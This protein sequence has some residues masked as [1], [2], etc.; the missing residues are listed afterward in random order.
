MNGS[1]FSFSGAFSP[2]GVKNNTSA[3]PELIALSS[4]DKFNLNGKAMG[5][6][7]VVPGDKIAIFDMRRKNKVDIQERFFI[8]KGFTVEGEELKGLV[9]IGKGGNFSHSGIYGAI[10]SMDSDVVACSVQ[11]LVRWDRGFI[12]DKGRFVANQ[13]IHMEVKS[14][15]DHEVAPG[16]VQ[17][18]FALTNFEV[19]PFTPNNSSD[20]DVSDV[21][22]E[23][24]EDDT[25]DL[26]IE[27]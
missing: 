13:K 25:D 26:E 23:D 6:I 24:E 3:R 16:I 15:G 5:N 14:I 12:N 2:S 21:D 18:V 1:R 11:D 20:E 19:I 7:A 8:T 17:E 27:L 9:T 4:K 10:M 22:Y